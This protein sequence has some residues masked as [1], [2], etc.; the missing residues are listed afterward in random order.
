M[1]QKPSSKY[2]VGYKYYLGYII[3]NVLFRPH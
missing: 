1:F 2:Y 3:H